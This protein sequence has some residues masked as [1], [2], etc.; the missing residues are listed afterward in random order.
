[1][2]QTM[3]RPTPCLC[4]L[5]FLAFGAP[6]LAA[7]DALEAELVKL[8]TGSWVAWKAHDGAYF[9]RFLSADHVEV[10]PNG[11]TAGADAIAGFVGSGACTVASYRI[12]DFKLTR[13][14]ED[15]ALLTYRADQDT[16]CGTTKVPSPVWATSLFVRRR[17]RWSNALYVH[18]PAARPPAG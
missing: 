1:M 13:F 4:A 2:E 10:Q 5:A 14:G 18:T 6:V 8:E 7:P 16:I 17:G 11:P 3:L 9:R 12:G 15:T